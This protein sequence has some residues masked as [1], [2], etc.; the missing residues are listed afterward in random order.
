MKTLAERLTWARKEKNM[1]QSELARAS[2][3]AQSNIGNLESGAR[4]TSRTIAQ[5]AAVL[6]VDALWLEKGGFQRVPISA[7][8]PS[9]PLSNNVRA[10]GD[11]NYNPNTSRIRKVELRL[12]AGINGLSI[13][14]EVED[15]NPIYFRND[16][17]AARGFNP[18]NLIATGITGPSMEPGLFEGDTVVVN[19]ADTTP[20]DGEVFA[21]NYEGECVVKRLVRDAGIW[22]LC[23]DNPD[24]RRFPRKECADDMCVVIGRVIHKQSERI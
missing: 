23:S 3:V 13:E 24:Q 16:W 22:W 14:Q 15:G 4:K 1:T 19:T 11:E 6:G 10:I 8:I 12:S 20:K 2:G 21:V 7:A 18:D 17:L 9:S 5:L